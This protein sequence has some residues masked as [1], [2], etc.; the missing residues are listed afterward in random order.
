VDEV[1]KADL[2]GARAALARLAEA[3]E[4]AAFAG[5]ELPD[6]GPA[7]AASLGPKNLDAARLA[8]LLTGFPGARTKALCE[9]CLQSMTAEQF[10]L[11]PWGVLELH[12]PERVL[13]RLRE[14]FRGDSVPSAARD[15][16]ARMLLRAGDQTSAVPL[17]AWVQGITDEADRVAMTLQFGACGGK[18]VL[19]LLGDKVAK[20]PPEPTTANVAPLCAMV[21]A[22][23]G[24]TRL[25][26]GLLRELTA[27]AKDDFS[28]AWQALAE[29]LRAGTGPEAIRRFLAIRPLQRGALWG[30]GAFRDVAI[31]YLLRAREEREH[32]TYSWATGE[33]ALVGMPAAR[34]EIDGAVARRMYRWIDNLDPQVLVGRGNAEGVIRALPLLA[35]NCCTYCVLASRLGQVF[36]VD[37]FPSDDGFKP[38][39]QMVA[40]RWWEVGERWHWS[41]LAGKLIAAPR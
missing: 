40:E 6:P 16:A 37:P 29:P 28:A 41:W 11:M 2:D 4:M 31:P 21:A 34:D 33:L 22:F 38:R 18:D 1:A 13:A 3:V 30:L 7:L 35:S 23:A 10:E 19:Q 8:V 17:W 20:E 26:S 39:A 5:L 32:G 15:G 27:L 14:W 24:D 36:E 25:A 12:D 9:Q